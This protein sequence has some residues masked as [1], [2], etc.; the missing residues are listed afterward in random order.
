MVSIVSTG[1]CP[2][3]APHKH[4]KLYDI[5]TSCLNEIRTSLACS[6]AYM[7]EWLHQAMISAPQAE[8]KVTTPDLWAGSEPRVGVFGLCADS[9]L[10]WMSQR[11]LEAVNLLQ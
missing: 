4:Y 10:C 1:A 11:F 7:I 3:D 9:T 6:S 5:N 8:F 2:A